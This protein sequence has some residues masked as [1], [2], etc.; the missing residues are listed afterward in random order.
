MTR[1]ELSGAIGAA[2]VALAVAVFDETGAVTDGF[3][4][5]CIPHVLQ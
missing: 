4:L 3:A 5:G 1:R 2:I